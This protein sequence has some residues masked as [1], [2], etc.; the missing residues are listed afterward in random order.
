[1]QEEEF[2]V[3]PLLEKKTHILIIADKYNKKRHIKVL[4]LNYM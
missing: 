4:C 3:V 1:L 2:N